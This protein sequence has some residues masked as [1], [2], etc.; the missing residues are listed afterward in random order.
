MLRLSEGRGLFGCA[1]DTRPG[2]LPS[3]HDMASGGLLA[4]GFHGGSCGSWEETP[5][6]C[7]HAIPTAGLPLD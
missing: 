6:R 2:L 1:L 5:W 3:A 7:F 4:A